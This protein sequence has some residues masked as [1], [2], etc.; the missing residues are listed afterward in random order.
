MTDRG[1]SRYVARL[2]H[3]H[4]IGAD[5]ARTIP[6]RSV[7]WQHGVRRHDGMGG[8]ACWLFQLVL[9]AA[10]RAYVSLGVEHLVVRLPEC[11][12]PGHWRRL[13]GS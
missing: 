1:S 8:L 7:T 5:M 2:W 3:G 10:E 4:G 12:F 13:R 11:R 9:T 6:G